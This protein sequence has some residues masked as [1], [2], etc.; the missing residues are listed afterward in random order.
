MV[1]VGAWL[2]I[3]L[4]LP[5]HRRFPNGD[6]SVLSSLW[7][8]RGSEGHGNLPLIFP[9]LRVVQM[10]KAENRDSSCGHT[11]S[12]CLVSQKMENGDTL[13]DTFEFLK[14]LKAHKGVSSLFHLCMEMSPPRLCILSRRVS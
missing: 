8:V 9:N 6:Q 3:L 12:T 2:Y 11:M 7:S 4:G 13:N 1:I 14:S 10:A 5:C